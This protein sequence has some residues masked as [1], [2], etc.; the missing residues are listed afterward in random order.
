MVRAMEG[1]LSIADQYIIRQVVVKA[2]KSA[3][4]ILK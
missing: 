3:T 4:E 1:I 2:S